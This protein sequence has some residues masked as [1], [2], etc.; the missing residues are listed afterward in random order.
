MTAYMDR[1]RRLAGDQPSLQVRPRFRF[2]PSAPGSE[3]PWE[4][5]PRGALSSPF[6]ASDETPAHPATPQG[7]VPLT[8][9]PP[10][11]RPRPA[12]RADLPSPHPERPRDPARPDPSL[13]ATGA[14]DEVTTR[15]SAPPG[16]LPLTTGPIDRPAPPGGP[17]DHPDSAGPHPWSGVRRGHGSS[18]APPGPGAPAAVSSPPA[19]HAAARG[20]AAATQA[21][22]AGPAVP[23]GLSHHDAQR[24]APLPNPDPP[25]DP[26]D[27][28]SGWTGSVV[29][30]AGPGATAVPAIDQVP[31]PRAWPSATALSGQ[32]WTRAGAPA[33]ASRR[34]RRTGP[35]LSP[36]RT[37]RSQARQPGPTLGPSPSPPTR[38]ELRTR[39]PE[40][41]PPHR[42]RGTGAPD[43]SRP[44]PRK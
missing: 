31:S 37:G 4:R 20:E 30:P 26:P 7:E 33:Q 5:P 17:S 27:R 22:P 9:Y 36:A 23:A 6:D 13:A 10:A 43:G 1:V 38:P 15:L 3:P 35:G 32:T 14:N 24:S 29:V 19:V 44:G 40:A 41:R 11:R 8:T 2:E 21:P 25:A 34:S 16:E 39:Q 18:G 28:S 12:T 42:H